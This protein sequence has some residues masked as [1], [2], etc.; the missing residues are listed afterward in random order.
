MRK[1]VWLTY[2]NLRTSRKVDKGQ[3][4][5]LL[6]FCRRHLGS[7]ASFTTNQPE[8]ATILV[9]ASLPLCIEKERVGPGDFRDVFQ[10]WDSTVQMLGPVQTQAFS[11]YHWLGAREESQDTAQGHGSSVEAS[12]TL[13]LSSFG[14]G[15]VK[16]HC[17]NSKQYTLHLPL[18]LENGAKEW[19]WERPSQQLTLTHT[20]TQT[21]THAHVHRKWKH[22]ESFQ[23]LRDS[24]IK[25][26][27]KFSPSASGQGV[28]NLINLLPRW[29][30]SHRHPCES[31]DLVSSTEFYSSL[32]ALAIS[33]TQFLCFIITFVNF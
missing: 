25:D 13:P 22:W 26:T 29:M 1:L 5:C 14:P 27:S 6:T 19:C 2:P 28:S 31:S 11:L 23:V 4:P 7:S 3:W 33:A 24:L 21:G 18:K 17:A 16:C 32:G 9:L 12:Q 20:R 15:A 8:L 10:L 30:W